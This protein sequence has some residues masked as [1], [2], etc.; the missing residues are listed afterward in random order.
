MMLD[1]HARK[2]SSVCLLGV[3]VVFQSLSLL[4]HTP[5]IT[6]F[7]HAIVVIP[8]TIVRES[9]VQLG[10]RALGLVQILVHSST[11][12]SRMAYSSGYEPRKLLVQPAYT[13]ICPVLMLVYHHPMTLSPFSQ[14]KH[15]E[16]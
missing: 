14:N 7:H 12:Y 4:V 8:I 5:A 13:A 10:C 6:P 15:L 9:C 1:V 2:K 11:S 16:L 3:A